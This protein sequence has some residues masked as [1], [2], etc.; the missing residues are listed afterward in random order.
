MGFGAVVLMVTEITVLPSNFHWYLKASNNTD[1]R[2]FHFNQG[3]RL[4]CFLLFRVFIA[5]I[6]LVALGLNYHQFWYDED[7]V[8][9]G[10]VIVITLLL[11]G[12]NVM[13]TKTIIQLYR[14]RTR[15]R[16]KLRAKEEAAKKAQ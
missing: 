9:K 10:A 16:D 6:V 4:W 5:P 11:G 3:L 1:T 7:A 15:L 14:K 8:T 13:W 12:M 2:A